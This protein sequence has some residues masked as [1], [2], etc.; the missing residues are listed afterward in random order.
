MSDTKK[1][2]NLATVTSVTDVQD[3]DTIIM[4]R[5]G[6]IRR[7]TVKT[8]VEKSSSDNSAAIT[9]ANEAAT[10]AN[11]AATAAKEAQ[12]SLQSDVTGLLAANGSYAY[13]A[14]ARVAG[15]ASAVPTK[16]YGTREGL[17]ATLAHLKVGTVKDGVLQHECAPGRLTLAANGDDIAIDGTDGDVTL[18]VDTIIHKLR[19]RGTIGSD[20]CN[21]MG[22]G[23]IPYLAG[24]MSSEEYKPFFI[25][26]D[27]TVN[28]K[29]DGDTRSQ[30][31]C[32]YNTAVAGSYAAAKAYYKQTYKAN[33]YGYPNNGISSLNSSAQARNKNADANSIS[34]CQGLFYGWEEIWWMAMSLELGSLDI[35]APANFGYGCTNTAASASTF[36]DTAMSGVSGMKMIT[37]DG[38]ATYAGLWS[39]SLQIGTDGKAATN[40]ETINGSTQYVFLEELVHLRVFD[41]ITKN[42]LTAYIGNS[43]AIFT[44]LGTAVVTDGSVNL[45][46]GAGMTANTFYCQ[47]RNVPNCQGLADGVMTG[48]INFYIKLECSDDVYLSGGTTSM[49]GGVVIFKF[50]LPVY[51]GKAL[52]K[53]MFTQTEGFYSRQ[54]NTDGT[55]RSEWYSVDRP[56]N[57]RVINTSTGYADGNETNGILKGLTKRYTINSSGG[58]VKDTDYSVSIFVPKTYGGGQHTY[59]CS[60]VWN[61]SSWGAPHSS[62]SVLTQGYSC[63]NASAVGCNAFDGSA[64]RTLYAII[65][66]SYGAQSCAGAFAGF[67]KQGEA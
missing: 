49:K 23:L 12:S 48:V 16:E 13:Y 44:G 40:L 62:N 10:A 50:S 35:C 36:A 8:L 37:S 66:A 46:T 17:L 21:V 34:P 52:F 25:A 43:S 29:L 7:M 19:N 53:G 15:A 42:G 9:A 18:Y 5:N 26:A 4:E 31:H 32:I 22:L 30:A 51:R 54:T 41:N 3:S 24:S 2:Q 64:G 14:A 63:V 11:A 27:Y 67:L 38:T 60:Y 6:N 39:A 56:E 61:T 57:I 20:E 1:V 65:A 59:E 28:C 45:S 47:V 55:V 58:W 33:G